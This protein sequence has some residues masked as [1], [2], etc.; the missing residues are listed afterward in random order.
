LLNYSINAVTQGKVTPKK[1]ASLADGLR[2]LRNRL[3]AR[4]GRNFFQALEDEEGM[5]AER[6]KQVL[7]PARIE[8]I[9]LVEKHMSEA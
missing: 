3:F 8:S 9:E 4:Y 6:L 7:T 1:D 2:R 5:D